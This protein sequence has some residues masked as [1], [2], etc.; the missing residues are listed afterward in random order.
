MS[1]FFC[2]WKKVV[3]CLLACSLDRVVVPI[4]MHGMQQLIKERPDDPIEWIANYLLKNNPRK[5]KAIA[6]P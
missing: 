4:L 6:D 1:P 2:H 3:I 5:R